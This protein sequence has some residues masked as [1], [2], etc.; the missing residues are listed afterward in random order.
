MVTISWTVSCLAREGETPFLKSPQRQAGREGPS[1]WASAQVRGDHH[2][3]GKKGTSIWHKYGALYNVGGNVSYTVGI[4]EQI[5]FPNF[6]VIATREDV[7]ACI[8]A[9][10]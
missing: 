10:K 9:E 7:T 5:G 4:G 1:S 8:L 6:F 2:I 3:A